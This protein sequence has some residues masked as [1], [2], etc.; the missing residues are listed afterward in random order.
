MDL[1]S[2]QKDIFFLNLSLCLKTKE[3]MVMYVDI[4]IC[5]R[6]LQT[7]GKY[8]RDSIGNMEIKKN[9]IVSVEECFLK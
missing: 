2:A 5:R 1:F 3:E 8:K 9:S 6:I 4:M 7:L